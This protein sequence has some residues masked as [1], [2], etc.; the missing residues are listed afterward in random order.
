MKSAVFWGIMRR[1]VAIVS[2]KR[3]LSFYFGGTRICGTMAGGA[4][5]LKGSKSLI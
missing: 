5:D 4:Q 1:H 3:K 2:V